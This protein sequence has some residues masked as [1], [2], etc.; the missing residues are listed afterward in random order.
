MTEPEISV[1]TEDGTVMEDL[2]KLKWLLGAFL[3]KEKSEDTGTNVKPVVKEPR[4]SGLDLLREAMVARGCTKSQIES[5]VVGIILDILANSD[6]LYTDLQAAEAKMEYAR[7]QEIKAKAEVESAIRR[8]EA[9]QREINE[10]RAEFRGEKEVVKK[11]IEKFERSLSE[12]ETPEG[13]DAMSKMEIFINNVNVETKYDNTAYIVGLS[14]IL[15]NSPI[16]PVD[17]LKK[18]NTKL[19]MF[20]NKDNFYG[21]MC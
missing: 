14:A 12:C 7:E 1:V 21:R 11:Y 18:I 5:K 16:S 17:E 3:P 13:R 20:K 10:M 6:T 9:V 15:G 8:R 19:P 2:E 4:K